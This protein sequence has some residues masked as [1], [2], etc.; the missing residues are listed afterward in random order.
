M[1]E[2]PAHVR[3]NREQWETGSAEYQAQHRAQLNRFDEELG[4]GT[5]DIPER[6]I[7]VL[8]DVAG[9]RALE[10]GCGA[11]QS[12]IKL[13][14]LGARVIGI[15]LSAAQLREGR[16]NIEAAALRVPT[17]Q[18]DAERTPFRDDAF[19]LVW[20]DH[21]A[22]SFADPYR[23]VPEVARILRPGGLF[24]FCMVTPLMWIVSGNGDLT[25]RFQLPYFGMHGLDFDDPG[26]RTTEFQLPYGEWIRLFVANGLEVLDL[27]E[28][29][30]GPD[31]TSTYVGPR[32]LAWGR[33]FPYEHIWKLRK[34]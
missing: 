16:T 20:C 2:S 33:D 26:W 17:L 24:A 3:R 10:Y 13:A 18:A 4:W 9:L 27:V 22:M 12:G 28:L 29:R 7:A 1:S 15:D 21:G 11:S 5:W 6:E 30:P 23:T 31:A 19:E 8:G 14:K 32:E 25:R 34:G